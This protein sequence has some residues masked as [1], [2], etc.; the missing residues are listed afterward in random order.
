MLLLKAVV[1]AAA[2]VD[3]AAVDTPRTSQAGMD[4]VPSLQVGIT[5]QHSS[6]LDIVPRHSW[7]LESV[8]TSPVDTTA[9]SG[10]AVGGITALARAGYG[11]IFTASTCGRAIKRDCRG[12]LATA[13]CS[14][15]ASHQGRPL[16][17]PPLRSQWLLPIVGFANSCRDA[18]RRFRAT[19]QRRAVLC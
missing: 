8:H 7:Y 14:R 6:H 10:T 18:Q 13:T 19:V 5:P 15:L 12:K 17:L 4:L 2:E 9:I 1:V 3:T 11:R 16:L